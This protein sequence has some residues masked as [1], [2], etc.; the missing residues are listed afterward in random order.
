MDN[1]KTVCPIGTDSAK[2]IE[3]IETE[4]IRGCGTGDDLCRIVK[5]YWS[6]DGKLLAECDPFTCLQADA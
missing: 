4:S 5:Q 1:M 3:V 2:V 6:F